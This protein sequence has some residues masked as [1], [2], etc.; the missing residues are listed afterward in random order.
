[1]QELAALH[2]DRAGAYQ[3]GAVFV[4]DVVVIALETPTRDAVLRSEVVEFVIRL[5]AHQVAPPPL[6]VPPQRVVDQDRHDAE[7]GT[8]GW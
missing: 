5:V 4:R 1:M 7:N 3:A 2:L 6:T 8:L